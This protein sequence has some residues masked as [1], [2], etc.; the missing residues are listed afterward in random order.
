[1]SALDGFRERRGDKSP[2]QLPSWTLSLFDNHPSLVFVVQL[3]REVGALWI[4][5]HAFYRLAK[6]Y[7]KESDVL[8]SVKPIDLIG[9]PIQLSEDDQIASVKGYCV[10]ISTATSDA[11]R[12]LRTPATIPGCTTPPACLLARIHALNLAE[13][14]RHDTEYRADPLFLWSWLDWDSL[15]SACETCVTYLQLRN[16]ATRQAF[17]DQLPQMYGL[18]GW[19]ELETMKMEALGPR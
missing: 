4:L 13:V 14:D 10:Q 9:R 7:A 6:E 18:P 15:G 12:F 19:E 8:A 3:A 11:L 5:P 1:M 16:Q 2:W 17:W